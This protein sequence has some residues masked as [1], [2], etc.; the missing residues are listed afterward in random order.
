MGTCKSKDKESIMLG[1]AAFA[2]IDISYFIQKNIFL[3]F[4]NTLIA[5]EAHHA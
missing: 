1:L 3:F 4:Q 5:K 2:N